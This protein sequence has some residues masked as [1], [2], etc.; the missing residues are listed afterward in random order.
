MDGLFSHSFLQFF[1]K[2]N[3]KQ[4]IVQQKY[5][6]LDDLV[7]K[8]NLWGSAIFSFLVIQ[9]AIQM[10]NFTLC[11]HLNS[12]QWIQQPV[13]KLFMINLVV[14]LISLCVSTVQNAQQQLMYEVLDHS[15]HISSLLCLFLTLILSSVFLDY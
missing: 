3:I 7:Q 4:F 14:I 9:L 11:Y 8:Q 10:Q 5:S 12:C 2:I 6:I 13:Y 15:L 1:F